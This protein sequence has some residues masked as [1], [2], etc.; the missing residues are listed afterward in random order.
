MAKEAEP[1]RT[2]FEEGCIEL[3]EK[4]EKVREI[5]DELRDSPHM[6][7][8]TQEALKQFD[9]V[10][11]GQGDRIDYEE[12]RR[13]DSGLLQ[14]LSFWASMKRFNIEELRG[15]FNQFRATKTVTVTVPAQATSVSEKV[16]P[17][18]E[19][20][21]KVIELKTKLQQLKDKMGA[22][23]GPEDVF[24]PYM[25]E[26]ITVTLAKYTYK[27][28][29]YDK[30]SQKEDQKYSYE[31]NLGKWKSWG[32]QADGTADYKTMTFDEGVACWQGPLRNVKVRLECGDETK[33]VGVEEPST[34]HYEMV[35]K[36][37]AACTEA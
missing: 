31:L 18:Y 33:I 34:C 35:I 27:L 16:D 2:T 15:Y 28:C 32:T 7:D 11:E 13:G 14:K 4:F 6:N 23:F 29:F 20:E 26:C 24:L 25:D 9:E 5:F 19:T 22:D 17:V 1:V 12:L 37:P 30:V 10:V 21:S 3:Q 36:S 8:A